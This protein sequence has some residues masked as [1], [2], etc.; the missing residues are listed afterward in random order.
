MNQRAFNERITMS[1]LRQCA[2][3]WEHCMKF[4]PNDGAFTF[5]EVMQGFGHN[6]SKSKVGY[7]FVNTDLCNYWDVF[8]R[9]D[10]IDGLEF[11][12]YEMISRMTFRKDDGYD[13]TFS[14][15]I[16]AV[17]NVTKDVGSPSL[18][19]KTRF[20]YKDGQRWAELPDSPTKKA[21]KP[22]AKS[23][24]PT[25]MDVAEKLRLALMARLAA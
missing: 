25:A 1:L 7:L 13:F 17:F 22:K 2:W 20:C 21:N 4:A 5:G 12:R 23:P 19:N 16:D 8:N 14:F 3:V 18:L 9:N 15:P 6:A 11:D 10:R 24:K